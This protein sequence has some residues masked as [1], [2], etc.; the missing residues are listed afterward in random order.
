[1]STPNNNE[2]FEWSNPEFQP[3]DASSST[4][5]TIADPDISTS[6]SA[7][8]LQGSSGD[9]V[10]NPVRSTPGLAQLQGQRIQSNPIGEGG[11]AFMSRLES[12]DIITPST[13]NDIEDFEW[14]NPECQSADAQ[15]STV[16]IAGSIAD[17]GDAS[18]ISSSG[19]LQGSS[20][21]DVAIQGGAGSSAQS[22]AVK[23]YSSTDRPAA[24]RGRR[25]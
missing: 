8:C 15:S 3:A 22:Q 21:S 4:T 25:Q 19:S 24:K 11:V 20:G 14:P 1:M 5:S 2:D 16:S 13:P 10:G 9:D 12:T 23:R 6:S 17:P 7:G 18:A